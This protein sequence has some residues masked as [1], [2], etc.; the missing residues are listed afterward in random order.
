MAADPAL[1]FE[2]IE[3]PCHGDPAYSGCLAQFGLSRKTVT[4]CEMVN[5]NQPLDVINHPLVQEST[6]RRR[7]TTY[8][9]YQRLLTNAHAYLLPLSI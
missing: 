3:R 8:R 6:S 2:R 5:L 7:G 1:T 9:C 4:W